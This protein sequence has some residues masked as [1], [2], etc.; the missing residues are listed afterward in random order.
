MIKRNHHPLSRRLACIGASFIAIGFLGA[1]SSISVNS[2]SDPNVDYSQYRT[3]MV[4]PD[5]I[6]STGGTRL[7]SPFLQQRLTQAINQELAAKGLTPVGS[8]SEADLLVGYHVALKDKLDVN[9]INEV[10]GYPSSALV[11]RGAYGRYGRYGRGYYGVPL[12]ES[13][14]VVDAYE[15]GTL[16]L[17]MADR[18]LGRLVWRGVGQARV[19]EASSP[20]KRQARIREAVAS[21]LAEYP[22]G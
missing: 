21:I 20:E 5:P 19:H 14:T 13:R 18:K 15:Q 12:V 7:D 4:R 8:R 10:Y 6:S 9:V 22:P 2:D 17:D 1:C 16:V 3:F 11:Y